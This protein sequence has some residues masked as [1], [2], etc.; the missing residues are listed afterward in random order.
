[1]IGD[2]G[3]KKSGE[4]GTDRPLGLVF[5]CY[6]L[7]MTN[8]GGERSKIP[9]QARGIAMA[10]GRPNLFSS[11]WHRRAGLNFELTILKEGLKSYI[12]ETEG[13]QRDS[14]YFAP[15][16]KGHSGWLGLREISEEQRGWGVG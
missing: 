16:G 2:S 14:V 12:K 11:T 10:G 1:L 3:S 7:R 5:V 13:H 9:I 6:P 15:A 8:A 4:K